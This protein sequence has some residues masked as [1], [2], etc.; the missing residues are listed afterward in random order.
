MALQVKAFW[1]RALF[2]SCAPSLLFSLSIHKGGRKE[3]GGNILGS[4]GAQ[5]RQPL[6]I[7]FWKYNFVFYSYTYGFA[8][9]NRS[10]MEPKI[11]QEMT[12]SL[13]SISGKS[14][15]GKNRKEGQ[16]LSLMEKKEEG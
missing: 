6:T 3:K 10:N 2:P 4:D 9:R 13:C 12:F 5:N 1:I 14:G 16:S 15:D 7:P 11:E 8:P